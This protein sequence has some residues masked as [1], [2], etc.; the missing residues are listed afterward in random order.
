M[1]NWYNLSSEEVEKELATGRNN[2]LSD[3]QV[4]RKKSKIW[5]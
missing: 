2:G 3:E 1:K 5:F 4:A